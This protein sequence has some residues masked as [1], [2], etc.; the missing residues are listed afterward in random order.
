MKYENKPK[1][2]NI[3]LNEGDAEYGNPQSTA[4][5]SELVIDLSKAEWYAFTENYGTSQEKYL[6]KYI[7]QAYT[8]LSA[9]YDEIYLL[10]NQKHFTLYTFTEGQP[11]EPDFVL[12]LSHKKD[13]EKLTYK[14]FI[15]PKGGDRLSIE[16]SQI[17]ERF[18]ME[19][20]DLYTIETVFENKEFK[21][22]GTPLYNEQVTRTKFEKHL[23]DENILRN[24][25]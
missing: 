8:T 24:T 9:R 21:L 25:K 23:K 16:D 5:T 19:L 22:L 1:V 20:A 13:K 4:K 2:M 6:V 14:I 11:M 3:A 15:E 12:F 7:E 10:R 17:K 18:L